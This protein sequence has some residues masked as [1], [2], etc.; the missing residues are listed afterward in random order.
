MKNPAAILARRPSAG[1]HDEVRRCSRPMMFPGWAMAIGVLA[2]IVVGTSACDSSPTAPSAPA[3][4]TFQVGSEKF[5]VLLTTDEQVQAAE[6]AQEGGRASIPVG[7]IVPGVDVN[8]GWTWHLEEVKF[9]ETTVELCDG[10][11][12]AVEKMGTKFGE[13]QFCPWTAKVTDIK[14][15]S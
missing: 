15:A 2:S 9:V 6:A 12:S 11:P 10:L 8:A 14:P 5:S 7:R 3:I 4:A 1:R 13:G